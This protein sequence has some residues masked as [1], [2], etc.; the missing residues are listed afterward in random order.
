MTGGVGND[1]LT[2]VGREVTI[3]HIYGDALLALG[4]E[5]VEQQRIVYVVAGVTHTLAVALKG[6]ELV[7]IELFAVEQQTPYEGRFTVVD[8][9]GGEQAEKVFLLVAVEKFR[10]VEF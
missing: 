8:R 3:G 7:F 5:A 2:S 4:F 6:V 10:Y 9:A 1:E